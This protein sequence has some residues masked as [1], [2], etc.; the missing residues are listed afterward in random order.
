[1]IGFVSRQISRVCFVTPEDLR[2]LA[3]FFGLYLLLF[4]A[5]TLADGMSLALFV[6]RVGADA[7]PRYYGLTALLNL[8]VVWCYMKVVARGSGAKVFQG[9]LLGCL[10]L[11][12]L[13]W[14]ATSWLPGDVT[15]WY[16]LYFVAREMAYVLVLAHFGTFLQDYFTRAELNRVLPIIYAGGRCGG[17]VGGALLQHLSPLIG[18]PRLALVFAAMLVLACLALRKIVRSVPPVQDGEPSIAEATEAQTSFA[19]L[20]IASPLLRWFAA[21]SVLFMLV[22]WFLNYQYNHYF[23]IHFQSE[24]E[25]AAFLGWYT[26]WALLISLVAQVV[27]VNRLVAWTGIKGVHAL[28]ST[29]LL[30]GTAWALGPMTLTVAIGCRMLE[31]ELRY[32]LRNPVNQLVTNL[33]PKTTRVRIRAWTL[34]ALNPLAAL[35][36]FL[37]LGTLQQGG[38]AAWIALVG[39]F[40]AIAHLGASLALYAAFREEAPLWAFLSRKLRRMPKDRAETSKGRMVQPPA[41][42]NDDRSVGRAEARANRQRVNR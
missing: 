41:R 20:L 33:F 29:L 7:L 40:L 23:E 26:Q 25:L 32:G 21:T 12:G 16:G 8:V 11:F 35:L 2:R 15:P 3:P 22:R 10:G 18:V 6:R 17:L 19:R 42:P 9:I 37:V 5:L 31:S 38:A 4:S 30:L 1:M 13:A 28:S 36:A 14:A 39:L 27:L 34:G 24:V